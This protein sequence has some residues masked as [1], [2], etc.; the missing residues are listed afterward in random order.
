M[1]SA[2]SYSELTTDRL[3]A[4][5]FRA[6]QVRELDRQAAAALGVPSYQLMRRAG[7]AAYQALRLRWPDARRI[8]VVCGPGNNGGDGYVVAQLAH[9]EGLV[10]NLLALLPVDRLRGDVAL[11]AQEFLRAG[12][13]VHS[14]DGAG[15]NDY[16]VL[17]D[18]VFGTG[19]TRAPD[20]V[21]A[22]AVQAMN[23]SPAP[24]LA[25]DLPSGL[26][27]DRGT[28]LGESV[29]AA[30]TVTF[31]ALK[32]GLF[33]GDGPAYCGDIRYADLHSPAAV[34][35]AAEPAAR[36]IARYEGGLPRR[37]RTGHKGHYGHVLVV[38]GDQGY[39]GAA[40]LA[41]EA[42]ARCGAGLVTIATHPAHAAVLNLT[43]PELMVRGV[44]EPVDLAPL[45]QRATV[46]VIGPG[47]GQG[48]WGAALRRAVLTSGAPQVVDADAL[49]LLAQAPEHY[50]RWVLT[51][52]PAEAGRLLGIETRAVNADRYAAVQ[53]LQRRYGGVVV[54]KGAGTLVQAD[55]VP[56]VCA[57]GNPGMASGGMGD[58]LGGVIAALHAQGLD[59]PMAAARGVALHAAAGD[60][61][62]RGGERG[63][64][65]G[66]LMAPLRALVNQCD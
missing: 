65:A 64:L 30:M 35:A 45:L 62:A 14:F 4:A 59:L 51:P 25:L 5:L 13:T 18:A 57:L 66:D 15:L 48:P 55:D 16:Q 36:L 34:F 33:T 56:W 40:R 63:L 6:E 9:A 47:L 2:S 43:R 46:V 24:T 19:L 1:S 49:N 41:A 39:S 54:L 53:E 44:M 27:A 7:A 42:A 12:G 52:H 17:V 21:F 29:R 3:P 60:Q 61:A 58:V 11:A 32:T 26:E 50:A 10:V 38:G 22:A 37:E 20:G 23:A 8:A 28:A 31:V